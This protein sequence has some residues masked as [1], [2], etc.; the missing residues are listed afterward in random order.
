MQQKTKM[1]NNL[2]HTIMKRYILSIMAMMTI[3]F[4]ANA[5]SFSQAQREALF[6]RTRWRMNLI[7]P[8]SSMRLATK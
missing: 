5:M 3:A 6:R 4:N 8:T 2:K 7:S 1:C